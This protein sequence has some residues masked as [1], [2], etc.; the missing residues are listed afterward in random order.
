MIKRSECTCPCHSWIPQMGFDKQVIHLTPCCEPD[1]QGKAMSDKRDE[2]VYNVHKIIE[3]H[4][5]DGAFP[6][7]RTKQIISLCMEQVIQA[8]KAIPDKTA[9][10]S[11]YSKGYAD[12]AMDVKREA[13]TAV[14]EALE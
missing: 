14:K 12:G 1:N 11:E 7:A 6:Y 5:K 9:M 13:M 4:A 8:L 3:F 2:L 10:K